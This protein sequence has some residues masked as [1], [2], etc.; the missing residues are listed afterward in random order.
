M[1]S[2]AAPASPPG[3]SRDDEIAEFFTDNYNGLL[4]Y[5]ISACQCP[6]HE[7]DDI[8][9]DSFLA[10]RGQ[11]EHV[12]SYDKP[13]AYLY[14]VAVRLFG[15]LRKQQADRYYQG[16]PDEHLQVFPDPA[17]AF[18]ASDRRDAAL[19]LLRQLPLRQRQVL[20]LRRGAD[21]SEAETAEILTVS[22]GT[23]KS[24]LHDAT[25]RMEELERKARTDE[26][27]TE[28]W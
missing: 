27:R 12:R 18:A 25:A 26:W 23:V 20:W 22:A 9:M 1:V 14:K 19:A 17:D 11:W 6:E 4:R 8:A 2:P 16:D 7:A 10:V 24:Q 3:P 28:P 15:R 13:K 5:L 21:F